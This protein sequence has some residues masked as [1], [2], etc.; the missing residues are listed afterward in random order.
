M[1]RLTSGDPMPYLSDEALVVATLDSLAAGG[2]LGNEAAVLI[3]RV[4]ARM[5]AHPAIAQSNDP[6]DTVFE[7][8]SGFLI[9]KGATLTQVLASKVP[10]LTPGG[11]VG[12]V[13]SIV[14]NWLNDKWRQTA[15]GS[16]EHRLSQTLASASEFE[17]VA[18]GQ[19]ALVGAT[20]G[21]WDG[22]ED[23]LIAAAVAVAAEIPKWKSSGRRPPLAS[24][25]DTIAVLV[26]VLSRAGASLPI[27]V[28]TRVC[29]ARFPH[30]ADPLEVGFEDSFDQAFEGQ[31]VEDAALDAADAPSAQAE[32]WVIVSTMSDDDLFMLGNWTDLA[33]IG[34]HLGVGR[35]QA[36]ERRRKLGEHLI[37]Q[38]AKYPDPEAVE[39][40]IPDVYRKWTGKEF[41]S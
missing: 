22:N 31:S 14:T 6:E 20:L 27:S 40:A 13:V 1:G 23:D 9:E 39:R 2:S 29:L 19:W 28:L 12:I 34:T 21:T 4:M 5:E 10:Q 36:S 30:A 32:A 38:V 33:A 15:F 16:V 7:T 11:A 26:A 17:R 18:S 24:S 8:A 41:G 35:S 25:E 37:E 3:L